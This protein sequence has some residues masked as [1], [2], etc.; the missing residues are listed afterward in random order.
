MTTVAASGGLSSA[1]TLWGLI[2]SIVVVLGFLAGV[3]KILI[4]HRIRQ[5]GYVPLSDVREIKTNTQQLTT[6][7]GTHLA[8][9]IKVIRQL[10]E[11]FRDEARADIKALGDRLD[12]TRDKVMQMWPEHRRGGE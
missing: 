7:H 10:V 11:E 5:H 8:D 9:D 4:D 2:A 1:S 6:N 12:D 3:A